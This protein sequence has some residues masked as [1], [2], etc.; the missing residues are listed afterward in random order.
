MSTEN[1]IDMTRINPKMIG[2][3][4]SIRIKKIPGFRSEVTGQKVFSWEQE[5][6]GAMQPTSFQQKTA[7]KYRLVQ[8][9]EW[10]L[11]IARYDVY[12]DPSNESV[13]V[14]TNWGATFH[15]TNWDF[16]FTANSTLEIG[17]S[18]EWPTKL[19][20]FFPS[21]NGIRTGKGKD[22]G[23]T[24]FLNTV[25]LVTAFLDSIKKKLPN[26]RDSASILI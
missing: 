7:F 2:F 1:S 4:E 18:S 17:E 19:Q 16:T 25:Q 10:E 9:T 6:P 12:G 15:N 3:S 5:L 24:E 14:A 8:H 13:P 23:L 11:E 22:P 26:S 21:T 20:T